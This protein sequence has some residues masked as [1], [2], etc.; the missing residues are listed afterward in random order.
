[1]SKVENVKLDDGEETLNRLIM[2][3]QSWDPSIEK[4]PKR[5]D[6]VLW[7]R[8]WPRYFGIPQARRK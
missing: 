2:Q 7:W 1:M 8:T 3:S 6:P 4:L 5:R